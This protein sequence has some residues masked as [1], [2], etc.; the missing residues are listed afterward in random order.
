MTKFEKGVIVNE[1]LADN[2]PMDDGYINMP[3]DADNKH[4]NKLARE[5]VK[6]NGECLER[7]MGRKISS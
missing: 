3:L 6:Q 5:F 1:V 4:I 7:I 2:Y